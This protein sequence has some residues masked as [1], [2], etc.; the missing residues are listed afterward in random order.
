LRAELARVLRPGGRLILSG[1][2][3]RWRARLEQQFRQNG[4]TKLACLENERWRALV[5]SSA[6]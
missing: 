3:E 5:F 6:R 4:F 1:F 2:T